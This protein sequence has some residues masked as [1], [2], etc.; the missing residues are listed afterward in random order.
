MIKTLIL[1]PTLSCNADCSYCSAFKNQFAKWDVSKFRFYLERLKP[2]L[3]P[4]VELLWHGGE[5]MLMGVDFYW[6]SF[7]IVK[8]VIPRSR[9]SIQTNLLDYS[10]E[11][12]E[13]FRDVFNWS[14]S[15]SYSSGN[16]L[17]SYK[18]SQVTYSEVWREKL[19]MIMGHG[20]S[21]FIIGT[22]APDTISDALDFYTS[23]KS[24]DTPSDIR[25]NYVYPLGKASEN[26]E[27]LLS[28]REYINLLIKVFDKWIDDAPG[29]DIAPLGQLMKSAI[30]IAKSKCPF[31]AKCSEHIM[32]LDIDGGLYPCAGFADM[33]QS[34]RYSY[35][36]L[37]NDSVETI[38]LSRAKQQM[39]RRSILPINCNRCEYLHMCG[40]GCIKDAILSGGEGITLL[41][42]PDRLC[43]NWKILYK[44]IT[45]SLVKGKLDKLLS[46][47]FGR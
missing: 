44:Y 30:G 35:G 38:V 33:E 45:D 19:A 26:Q 42:S 17:R 36:N 7:D 40:G 34:E 37:N 14:I 22:F 1:R 21:P 11:W 13:L 47:R 24:Q 31:S 29:F 25:I 39:A 6:Q 28:Q 12:K 43:D 8:D 4:E 10:L 23:I 16:D 41:D 5:P 2:I 3:S 9:F 18:G 15:T 27:S 32:C 46:K 20:A